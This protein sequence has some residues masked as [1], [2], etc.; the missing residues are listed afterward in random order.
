MLFKKKKKKIIEFQSIKTDICKR[1]LSPK[2]LIQQSETLPVEL[3][4]TH[5]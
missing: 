3:T 1:G 2:F 5:K 4:E